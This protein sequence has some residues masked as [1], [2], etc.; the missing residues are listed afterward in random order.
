[1]SVIG[2]SCQS[3]I[4]G[5]PVLDVFVRLAINELS[6]SAVWLLLSRVLQL[7]HRDF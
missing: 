4:F 6:I 7:S 3:L 2:L 5:M 1:M